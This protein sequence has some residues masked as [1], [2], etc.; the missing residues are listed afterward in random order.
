MNKKIV[1]TLAV[2]FL[3]AIFVLSSCSL[4]KELPDKY[5]KRGILAVNSGFADGAIQNLEEALS[6]ID[7]Y[8][9]EKKS[10]VNL[11]IGWAYYIKNDYDKAENYFDKARLYCKTA[12]L[13]SGVLLNYS[14]KGDY[15][16]CVSFSHLID[17]IPYDWSL[18]V[19]GE[20]ILKNVVQKSL[21]VSYAF[22]ND[23]NKYVQYR[24]YIPEKEQLKIEE[25]FFQ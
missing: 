10:H 19:N 11:Y 23:Y 20:T 4:F 24:S 12:D 21:G 22:L 2:V 17:E 9:V 6:L 18:K 16:S 25:V 14:A 13:Y 1:F 5:I 7:S 3:V 8:D 15:Q